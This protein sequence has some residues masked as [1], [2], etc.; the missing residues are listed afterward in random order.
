MPGPDQQ[1]HD[2]QK[3]ASELTGKLAARSRHVCMLLGAGAGKAAGL[4]DFDE[5]KE[6]VLDRIDAQDRE[7][8]EKIFSGRTIEDALSW[9]RKVASVLDDDL[10]L[11][12]LNKATASRLDQLICKAVIDCVDSPAARVE[13]FTRLAT[14]A[15]GDQYILPI[16][17]FTVSYDVL[18]ERGLESVGASYF[19]GFVGTMRARFRGDLVETNA[20]E[21]RLPAAFVRL[22][23]LHGSITW[24]MDDSGGVRQVVRLG[25]PVHG[26]EVAAIYPSEE[27]YNDSRRVPFVILMD[28]FRRALAEPETIVLVNGYSFGDQ[29]LNEIIFEAALRFPRSETVVLCHEGIPLVVKDKALH[30][31]NVTALGV[32]EAVVGGVLGAWSAPNDIQDVCSGGRFLLGD[33]NCFGS[34]LAKSRVSENVRA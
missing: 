25:H 22:W 26:E 16:E 12:G 13:P 33:F 4:P 21:T 14:W 28:R 18:V 2:A 8:V 3:I 1:R 15:A 29:H 34:F 7:I 19:D 24:A 5:L 32:S 31:K 11:A 10:T 20:V 6:A 9:I 23:K 27:K 30:L 17:I